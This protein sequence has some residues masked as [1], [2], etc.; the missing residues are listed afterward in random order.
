MEK[1][2]FKRTVEIGLKKSLKSNISVTTKNIVFIF[3]L[4]N[5]LCSFKWKKKC[6][7]NILLVTEILEF[8]E[9]VNLFS[10]DH[11][12]LNLSITNKDS[13]LCFLYLKIITDYSSLEEKLIF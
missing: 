2:E 9:F 5:T 4:K 6:D 13:E 3:V 12:S 8:K 11:L 10:A 7:V 1:F